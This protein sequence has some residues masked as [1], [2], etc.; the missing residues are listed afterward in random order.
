M[1]QYRISASGIIIH[2]QKVVLAQ[3]KDPDGKSFFVG[4]GGGIEQNEPIEQALI[5]EIKEET[6][7]DIQPIKILLI[8]DLLTTKYRILKIWFWC[9][10]LGGTLAQQ[11]D[12]AIAEGII[13][14]NWYSKEELTNKTVYPAILL[15]TDWDLFAQE[16]WQTQCLPPVKAVF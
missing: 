13:D 5:R 7:L 14:V 2:R 12:E 8:E 11:T 16:N 10:I 4:P 3:C 1:N 9:E 15:A 6:R